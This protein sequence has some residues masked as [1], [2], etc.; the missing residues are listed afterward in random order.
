MSKAN[1]NVNKHQV[2]IFIAV[3]IFMFRIPVTEGLDAKIQAGP[4]VKSTITKICGKNQ[5][6]ILQIVTNYESLPERLSPDFSQV[7]W[8]I[9]VTFWM[10][11]TYTIFAAKL[12]IQAVKD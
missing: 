9:P 1:I 11:I 6:Y 12:S 10:T 8:Y 5:Y 3:A 4:L 7:I 2:L